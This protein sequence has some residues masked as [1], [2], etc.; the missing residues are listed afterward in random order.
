VF[1]ICFVPSQPPMEYMTSS[2]M[3]RV[4]PYLGVSIGCFGIIFPVFE[5]ILKTL[6]HAG[7]LPIVNIE[8]PNEIV[9]EYSLI[10]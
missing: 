10:V 3:H 1:D 6:V 2:V 5:L 4:T 9:S 8:F 7:F